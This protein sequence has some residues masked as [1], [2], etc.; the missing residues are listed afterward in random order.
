MKRLVLIGLVCAL[1]PVAMAQLYKYVDKDGKTVYTDQPPATVDPKE[2]KVQSAPTPGSAPEKAPL[3]R[4]KDQAKAKAKGAEESKKAEQLAKEAAAKQERC[5]SA[6]D[7]YR[8]FAD[9]GRVYKYDEKGERVYMEEAEM[10]SERDKARRI[11]DESCK[12]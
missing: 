6:T 3:E 10:A 12:R 5:Q 8:S 9:G 1:S 11:M 2:M 7:R 4:E